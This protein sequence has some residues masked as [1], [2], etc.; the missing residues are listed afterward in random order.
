MGLNGEEGGKHR[1]SNTMASELKSEKKRWRSR[2]IDDQRKKG[3]I[4]MVPTNLNV[5]KIITFIIVTLLVNL[6]LGHSHG[7]HT[8]CSAV[9]YRCM[10]SEE[11]GC[12]IEIF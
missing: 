3:P 7:Y 1:Y 5:L 9:A 2:I 12:Q 10:N 6:D 8:F 4:R 11:Q